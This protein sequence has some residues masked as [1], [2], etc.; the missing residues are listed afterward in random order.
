[1]FYIGGVIFMG[2]LEKAMFY[3]EFQSINSTGSSTKGLIFAAELV[4]CAKRTVARMLVI[5]VSVGFGIVKPR[6]GPT[7]H[8]GVG[9]LY[10][11]LSV[12][13]AYLRVTKPKND[14]STGMMLAGVPLAV[15]DSAICW[16]VFTALTTTLP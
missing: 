8:L 12:T 2:M 5:I 6:L 16:W 3:A 13:E 10:F 11:V 9:G 14:V 1:M 4:S 7:L 15:I